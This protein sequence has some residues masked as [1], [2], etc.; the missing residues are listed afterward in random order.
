MT[1]NINSFQINNLFAS[2]W[3]FIKNTVSSK[4]QPDESYKS[5]SYFNENEKGD[6]LD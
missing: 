3:K 4:K 6:A 2:P 1:P 5:E